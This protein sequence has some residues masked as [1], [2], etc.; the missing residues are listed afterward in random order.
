MII[1]HLSDSFTRIRNALS[2]RKKTVLLLYSTMIRRIIQIIYKIGYLNNMTIIYKKCKKYIQLEL[3]YDFSG[4]T[5]MK[6][7]KRISKPGLRLYC[8]KKNLPIIYN[9]IGTAIISTS[10]GLLTTYRAKK[11]KLGGEII[12]IIW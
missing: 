7:I 4:Q 9:G 10:H 2:S 8:N 12:C 5:V 6:G 1:D 11:E 3:K